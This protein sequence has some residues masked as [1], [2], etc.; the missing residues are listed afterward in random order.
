MNPWYLVFGCILF[1]LAGVEA[2]SADVHFFERVYPWKPHAVKAIV[3]IVL[4]IWLVVS[5]HHS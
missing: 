3:L 4:A 2:C 5:T 1:F